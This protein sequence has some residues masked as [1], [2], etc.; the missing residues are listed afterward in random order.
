FD[1]QRFG[2]E[3]TNSKIGKAL[4]K[5]NFSE[6]CQTLR[7]T[8]QKND[9]VGALKQLGRR[10][11]LLFVHSYQSLI[12][13]KMLSAYIKKNFDATFAIKYA[14]GEMI[15]PKK[16]GKIKNFEIPLP[17]FDTQIPKTF[18]QIYNKTLKEE[19]VDFNDFIIPQ[20]PELVT[21]TSMRAAFA[22][23][24]KFSCVYE[25]DELHRGKSK[26]TLTFTLNKGVYATTLVKFVNYHN[27]TPV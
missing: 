18:N 7:L 19:G 11:L 8:A 16:M 3:G 5:K 17:N 9:F 14:H 24:K 10:K 12:F 15:F 26:A 22:E 13:N 25:K 23:A 20:F 21:E 4:I 6:A 2:I 27:L 1:D